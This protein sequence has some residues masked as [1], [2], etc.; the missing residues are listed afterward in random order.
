M[1]YGLFGSSGQS[2]AGMRRKTVSAGVIA[3]LIGLGSAGAADA[4]EG[5]EAV[6]SRQPVAAQASAK[7]VAARTD[8]KRV[9]LG[10]APWICTPSGFGRTA[11][12]FERASLN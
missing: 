11:S 6:K 3:I 5:A 4:E 8:A 12:C 1:R 10:R 9:Y 7:R 2:G